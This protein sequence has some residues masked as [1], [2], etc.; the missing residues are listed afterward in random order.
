M[1]RLCKVPMSANSGEGSVPRLSDDNLSQALVM[2]G[3]AKGLSAQGSGLRAT[4]AS[5]GN[6]PGQ[7]MPWTRQRYREWLN[8]DLRGLEMRYPRKEPESDAY[9]ARGVDEAEAVRLI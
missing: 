1:E 7:R 6:S 4:N 8:A 9:R 3:D 2:P 5:F